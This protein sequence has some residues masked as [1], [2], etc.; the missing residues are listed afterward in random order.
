MVELVTGPLWVYGLI[1]AGIVLVLAARLF[2][3]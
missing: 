3:R 1:A 2:K